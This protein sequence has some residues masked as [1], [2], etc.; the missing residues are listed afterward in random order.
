MRRHASTCAALFISPCFTRN[1]FRNYF[2]FSPFTRSM[3]PRRALRIIRGRLS[4]RCRCVPLIPSVTAFIASLFM[5]LSCCLRRGACL[6]ARRRIIVCAINRDKVS[7]CCEMLKRES[8]GLKAQRRRKAQ[9]VRG[10]LIVNVHERPWQL[11]ERDQ[12]IPSVDWLR[13]EARQLRRVG[14]RRRTRDEEG[15]LP[16]DRGNKDKLT[17]RG[18]KVLI[19][20]GHRINPVV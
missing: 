12:R 5:Q 9:M 8:K 14:K 6:P 20:F 10:K 13:E 4:D 11:R 16:A 7:A 2:P 15:P 19:A 1:P 17:G 3:Q 18:T